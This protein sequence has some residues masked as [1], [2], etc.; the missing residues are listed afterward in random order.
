MSQTQRG[1]T[2]LS[3]KLLFHSWAACSLILISACK[4]TQNAK[5]MSAEDAEAQAL[6]ELTENLDAGISQLSEESHEIFQNPIDP[7]ENLAL[8]SPGHSAP[9]ENPAIA[10]MKRVAARWNE[11][12]KNPC[13]LW[14][15][16]LRSSNSEFM[17]PYFF[18]GASA[19]AGV[20]VHGVVGRDLVWD[21]YNLQF[22]TFTYKAVEAVF[23]SGAAGAG[24]NGYL[25]VG[26]GLR[27]D[28]N[29]AWSGRFNSAGLNFSLPVLSDYLSGHVSYFT[30]A[31]NNSSSDFRF[32][33][34]TVGVSA[35]LSAP[36]PL[37]GALQVASGEWTIDTKTNRTFSEKL[38]R[39][40]IPHATKGQ[41]TCGGNC[42]RLDNSGKG[43][44]YTGRAVSL[45]QSIPV[46]LSGNVLQY[47]PGLDQ[48]MLLGLAVGAYRDSLNSAYAC[49][50]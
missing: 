48:I 22:A 39:W 47:Y 3:L 15:P 9:R 2:V 36:T 12:K 31:D 6:K 32:R 26:F 45:A 7:N 41:E 10:L 23:G 20:G 21:Y 28:V 18:V 33:G 14:A 8:V 29:H 37:P 40:K 11:A 35:A 13:K 5:T 16:L 24:V 43:K 30:A 25:G 17:H 27:N 46:I 1:C 38:A 19:E 44:G 50:R 4:P 34:G 49:R 42:V